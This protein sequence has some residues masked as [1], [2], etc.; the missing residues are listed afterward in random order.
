M[1]TGNDQVNKKGANGDANQQ[2]Q[3]SLQV[4]TNPSIKSGNAFSGAS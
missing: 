1:E 4:M 3:R 2:L